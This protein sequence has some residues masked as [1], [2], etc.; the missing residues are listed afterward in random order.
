MSTREELFIVRDLGETPAA[1]GGMA[2]S[3]TQTPDQVAET[4]YLTQEF[5]A[6]REQCRVNRNGK[7]VFIGCGDDRPVTAESAAQLASNAPENTLS[8]TK[9]Y[10]SIYGGPAGMAK[11]I[12][13]VGAAQYGEKFIADMGGFE[14]VM[15]RIARGKNSATIHSAEG[16]EHS[17]QTFCAH[18]HDPVGCAYCMGVGATSDLVVNNPDLLEVGRADQVRVF[19]SDQGVDAL[20]LGH[21]R[22]LQHATGGKGKDFAV[23]RPAYNRYFG[24]GIR[25]MNL[26]G[27]H[28]R[29]R[30]SGVISDFDPSKVGNPTSAHADGKDYYRLD[31]GAVT[32]ISLEIMKDS[33]YQLSPELLARAYQL[34]STPV[35][36]VLA[37]HDKD[38]DVRQNADARTLPM[39]YVGNPWE[40]ISQLTRKYAA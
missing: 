24:E 17:P 31:I 36:L 6:E 29:A 33:G 8:P 28:V 5:L 21:Q 40:T 32:D 25:F 9:G 3:D 15:A 2:V 35:R 22:Y 18:G 4:G 38:E 10:A 16:N 34:D 39:G 37:M 12:L 26:S 23:D 11:N 19:G 30:S 27:S 1:I 14:G 13:V 20:V 7:H